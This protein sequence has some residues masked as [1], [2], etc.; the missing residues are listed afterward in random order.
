MMSDPMWW[1]PVSE[2]SISASASGSISVLKAIITLWRGSTAASADL[3]SLRLTLPIVALRIGTL[4]ACSSLA[5]AS[6]PPTVS[7]FIATP[8]SSSSMESSDSALAAS[9]ASALSESVWTTRSVVPA[10]TLS[11]SGADILSPDA[12]CATSV[13][14]Q[15]SPASLISLMPRGL[16]SP[17]TRVDSPPSVV[18]S[19][20]SS[21]F[22]MEPRWRM[23][24]SVLPSPLSSFI[25]RTVPSP[26]PSTS[27]SW[28]VR[29]LSARPMT[30]ARRSC[31]P[32]PSRAEMGTIA[33][34]L[35]KSLTRS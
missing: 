9:I 12:A 29:Y 17:F 27:G 11:R 33:M 7:A 2:D 8:S 16:K 34:S 13:S 20:I 19:T 24:S 15:R 6:R 26:E 23:T 25:S 14:S 4:R 5:S 10:R 30:T 3:T 32:S 1:T 21:P 35:V 31:M 18:T 22:L 28:S